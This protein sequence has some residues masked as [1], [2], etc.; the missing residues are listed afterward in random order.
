[1]TW[2]TAPRIKATTSKHPVLSE[3]FTIPVGDLTTAGR[4]GK[5]VTLGGV[6]RQVMSQYKVK[7]DASTNQ[8]TRQTTFFLKSEHNKEIEKAKKSL[9]ALLSPVVCIPC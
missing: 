3:S 1:M 2:A 4:D 8:K 9:L 6:M 5:S 7:L